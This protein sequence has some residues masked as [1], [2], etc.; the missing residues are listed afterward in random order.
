MMGLVYVAAVLATALTIGVLLAYV[1]VSRARREGLY[2]EQGKATMED[3]KRL[4]FRGHVTLA[5]SAYREIH[6]VSL[7]EAKSAVER[8]ISAGEGP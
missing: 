5:I 6:R 7:K 1:R 4:A 3:V 8:I 2:P